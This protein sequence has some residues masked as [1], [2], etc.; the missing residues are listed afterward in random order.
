ML[1]LVLATMLC[2]TLGGS[3]ATGFQ[4]QKG[5]RIVV[6]GGTFAERMQHK[7]FV[8][9]MLHVS[10]PSHELSV[11]NMGW[12]GDTVDL[13]PRP[14]DFGSLES[15]LTTA[16]ADAILLCFGA[17][18][19][20]A[21]KEGLEN[22]RS[23][24]EKLIARLRDQKF[25]GRSKPRL[26]LVSPIAQED[27]GGRFPD[28]RKHNYDLERYTKLISQV[29]KEQQLAFIDIYKPTRSKMR[30]MSKL[31]VNGVHLND[32]GQKLLA[33]DLTRQRYQPAYENLRQLIVEKNRLFFL[34]WRPVNGEYVYGRRKKPFGV[35]TYPPEMEKLD[36]M[37]AELDQRISSEAKRL[38]GVK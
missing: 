36:T 12:S 5:D 29:A 38:G 1:R 8:E 20:F 15:H 33:E 22:F 37:V 28:P 13:M 7:G 31:T 32:R 18:E 17:N 3:A 23:G 14:L 35:L 21:G 10:F 34:R 26:V 2:A 16:E 27:I 9:T 30:A 4:P 11:R 25:N 19:A 6:L 24:L